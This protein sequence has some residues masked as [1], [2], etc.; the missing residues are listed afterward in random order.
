MLLMTMACISVGP[1]EQSN[2]F[3]IDR[4]SVP[5]TDVKQLRPASESTQAS[6]PSSVRGARLSGSKTGEK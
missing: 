2:H 5:A 6:A 3:S 1:V 4:V